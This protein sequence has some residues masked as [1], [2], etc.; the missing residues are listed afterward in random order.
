MA[1]PTPARKPIIPASFV[2]QNVVDAVHYAP[3]LCK[4]DNVKLPSRVFIDPMIL[5]QGAL[6]VFMP[7]DMSIG[8]P[9]ATMYEI[10]VYHEY[11][12]YVG[13]LKYRNALYLVREE[14]EVY[15]FAGE[16]A[17]CWCNICKEIPRK[18]N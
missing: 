4:R 12:H 14:H 7:L 5:E 16:G 9:T 1:Y 13:Q 15:R 17:E 3:Y 6:G 2:G 11:L 10:V 8:F 18:S